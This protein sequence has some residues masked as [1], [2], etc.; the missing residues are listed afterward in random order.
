M[1]DLSKY[2]LPEKAVIVAR[3]IIKH[4]H[5]PIM[6][7]LA[8]ELKTPY[9]DLEWV[10]RNIKYRLERGDVLYEPETTFQMGHGDC[11]DD[12]L[13]I[14]TLA[15]IQGY[16]VRIRIIAN[17]TRHIYPII[18]VDGQWRAFDAV[19]HPGVSV[20]GLGMPTNRKYH[21]VIDG[22]VSPNG[23]ND[24]S[25]LTGG[26]FLQAIITGAGVALGSTMS[27]M[28][29][30][31]IG[32]GALS[33]LSGYNAVDVSPD[34]RPQTGDHLVFYYK[35]KWYLPKTLELW[36][37]KKIVKKE[38][39]GIKI[40]SAN[41]RMVNGNKRLAVEVTVTGTGNNLGSLT[42]ILT[43]GMI[44]TAIIGG[45]LATYFS[46]TRVQKIV[47]AP[48]MKSFM[49]ITPYAFLLAAGALFLS[50][51]LKVRNG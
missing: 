39:P 22:L 21:V 6:Q 25:G 14:G 26:G 51:L 33:G 47:T 34:Y 11:E 48:A 24:L 32:L 16:P 12:C 9:N 8:R 49:G 45:G 29:T 7:A 38:M 18:K 44:A 36:L 20:S 30:S 41:Y 40:E 23:L 50:E 5:D 35:P 2:T 17:G 10:K 3:E 4:E 42:L 1:I 37:I 31:K 19:P 15:R 46:L 43:V 27:K 13:L 28:I